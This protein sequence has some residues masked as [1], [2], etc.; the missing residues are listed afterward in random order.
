[1]NQECQ[2][3]APDK[4]L[5]LATGDVHI[6]RVSLKQ[7]AP[8]VY[9]LSQVLSGDEL[10]RSQK[11]RFE[12]D[13]AS[14]IIGRGVLRTILGRYLSIEA[15]RLSFGYG[16]RGKPYL[17]EAFCNGHLLFNL[18]HS[19]DLA[20]YAFTI[21]RRIG[22]DLEYLRPIV[23]YPQISA[24]FFSSNESAKLHALPEEQKLEAFYNCWTRKEAYIKATGEGLFLALDQ[25]EVSLTPGEPAQLLS[26]DGHPAEVSRWSLETIIPDEGYLA[27]II[28]EGHDLKHKCWQFNC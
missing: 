5:A 16:P 3:N 7:S 8:D 4:N 24:R 6:W 27:S 26:V 21:D 18:S 10:A 14:F 1:M 15:R 13:R 25:F 17:S 11:F 23:D 19:H 2:W 22:I 28:V 9:S 20:L 12:K